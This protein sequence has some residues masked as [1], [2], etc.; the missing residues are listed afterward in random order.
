MYTYVHNTCTRTTQSFIVLS[1]GICG[2]DGPFQC[3]VGWTRPSRR[4][5]AFMTTLWVEEDSEVGR[6][7]IMAEGINQAATAKSMDKDLL[8]PDFYLSTHT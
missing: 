6:G 2:R 5:R 3:D 7:A 8:G 4:D 1:V